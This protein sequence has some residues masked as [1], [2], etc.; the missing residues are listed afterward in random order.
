M[1]VVDRDT[2]SM[3]TLLIVERLTPCMFTPLTVE[4]DKPCMLLF[5]LL[6]L[7]RYT[8]HVHPGGG[9]KRNTLGLQV[10]THYSRW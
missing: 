9:A 4:R 10:I 6:T 5:T 3:P 1:L 8:L 2:P 7:E